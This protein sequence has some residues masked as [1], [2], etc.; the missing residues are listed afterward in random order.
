LLVA[1]AASTLWAVSGAQAAPTS[2]AITGPTEGTTVSRSESPEIEVTGTAAFLDV[3]ASG[4][5]SY[6]LH[7]DDCGGTDNPH[8]TVTASTDSVAD[9]CGNVLGVVGGGG[10]SYPATDGLPATLAPG[11]KVTG[12]IVIK[13][14]DFQVGVAAGLATAHV[15]VSATSPAGDSF[16]LADVSKDFVVV[17]GTPEYVVDI[18]AAVSEEAAG[19]SLDSLSVTTE[20]SNGNVLWGFTALSG[21]SYVTLPTLDT[22]IVQVAV[23]SATF[24]SSKTY[25]ATVSGGTWTATVP[26]PAAGPRKIYA[27]AVQNGNKTAA[28]PVSIT[29]TA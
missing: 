26:T 14:F 2:V 10:D 22:G 25:P 11:A 9:G 5:R 8:M 28:A 13:T 18:D 23:D 4:P 19:V 17:P 6:F 27:R 16:T 1:V 12:K 20:Y 21:R 15:T 3:P 24:S 7:Q 29:V